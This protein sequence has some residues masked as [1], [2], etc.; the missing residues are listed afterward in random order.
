MP[1]PKKDKTEKKSGK[2]EKRDP[3]LSKIKYNIDVLKSAPEGDFDHVKSIV[4]KF[5]KAGGN[6]ICKGCLQPEETLTECREEYLTLIESRPMEVWTKE[7]SQVTHREK[8]KVH[9]I[10]DMGLKC[11]TCYMAENCPLYEKKSMCA[12]DWGEEQ[13][14][15]PREVVDKLI[16]IQFQ[17]INRGSKI[18]QIDG[19]VP[20]Q[21][22]SSE[23]DRMQ[24]L[25][26]AR[27]DIDS[28]KFTL[29]IN[30][31]TSSG[32][33][34]GPGILAQL[35]GKGSTPPAA[36]P[37]PDKTI[38]VAHTIVMPEVVKKDK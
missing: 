3:L 36:L 19:G 33:Q 6:P 17:R 10:L 24:A 25:I 26:Q 27:S 16:Q 38:D 31:K 12:I 7:F 8:K 34:S 21:V 4:C 32:Q 22:L 2:D 37:E 18:E 5:F 23:I 35:L 15:S 9:E 30:S 14:L 1:S 29:K 28:D 20:D 13:N 11:D